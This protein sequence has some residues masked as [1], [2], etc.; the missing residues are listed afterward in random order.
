MAPRK[1]YPKQPYEVGIYGIFNNITGK[2]YI[3]SS[4]ELSA[5]TRK[6]KSLEGAAN[7][8]AATLKRLHDTNPIQVEARRQNVL[9]GWETRR[10]CKNR[11][12][13][14]D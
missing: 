12:A 4:T 3:G 1:L 6:P 13:V 2:W 8:A 10:N 5:S 7:I 14:N 9:K 11:I